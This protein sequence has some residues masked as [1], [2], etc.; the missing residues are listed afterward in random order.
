[1]ANSISSI[2]NREYRSS[3]FVVDAINVWHNMSAEERKAEIA[4]ADGKLQIKFPNGGV[5][6][7]YED[8]KVNAFFK[9]DW[10]K[11]HRFGKQA[12]MHYIKCEVEKTP[13]EHYN[14]GKEYKRV[15]VAKPGQRYLDG[16]NYSV[17]NEQLCNSI[18]RALFANT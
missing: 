6:K 13:V 16:C 8:G 4:A 12:D 17:Y 15:F 3:K 5:L 9:Q 11:L 1:M 7:F 2:L 18:F 10:A 14:D